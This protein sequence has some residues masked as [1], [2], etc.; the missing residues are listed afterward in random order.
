MAVFGSPF[1]RPDVDPL[2]AVRSALEMRKRLA[3]Y[4]LLRKGRGRPPIEIGI[5]ISTGDVVCGNIGSE[6]RMEYTAIGDGVNLASRLEGATKQY[7]VNLMISEF[8]RERVGDEFLVRE[9]DRMRVKGKTK[10][11]T[12]YEVLGSAAD[13]RSPELVARLARH[14]AAMD[15][16]RARR[17]SDALVAFDEACRS[18][19]GDRLPEMYR[20]RCQKLAETPPPAGW[21]GVW[22]L[23]DK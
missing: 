8:T 14:E 15:L 22:D 11:V 7:G 6:K 1:S 3:A 18:A 13:E 21:D 20:E 16:Y 12:V 5:G 10:P 2:N 23:K 19:P 4:N 17:W 9:L